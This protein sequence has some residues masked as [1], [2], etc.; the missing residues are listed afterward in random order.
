MLE[1]GSLCPSFLEKMPVCSA[2]AGA[3]S[4]GHASPLGLLPDPGLTWHS[5]RTSL[6]LFP[7]YYIPCQKIST[8]IG[9]YFSVS[10]RTVK[11]K[12][13]RRPAACLQQC[14][15]APLPYAMCY[16]TNISAF[17]V[18]SQQVFSPLWGNFV[19]QDLMNF[20]ACLSPPLLSLRSFTAPV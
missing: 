18:I 13:G 10:F 9:A 2:G 17:T 5:P 4:A 6:L 20:A 12:K 14:S 1:R 8:V 7:Q 19:K 11:K 16:L 15:W 3:V